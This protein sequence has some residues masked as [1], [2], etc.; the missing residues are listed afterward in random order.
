MGVC[1]QCGEE[2][3][4]GSKFC[5]H[6]GYK[7]I[8]F[9][10]NCGKQLDFD[11][12]FC[13]N[14]GTETGFATQTK[15]E[16]RT[17]ASQVAPPPIEE[18]EKY[19]KPEQTPKTQ[20]ISPQSEIPQTLPVQ[21]PVVAQP[22]PQTPQP[23][24]PPK[25]SPKKPSNATLIAVVAIAVAAMLIFA[26]MWWLVTQQE[27]TKN[28]TE[29][30]Q[31]IDTFNNAFS[32]HVGSVANTQQSN[33]DL[34]NILSDSLE[35]DITNPSNINSDSA[36]AF[37][38]KMSEETATYS[39][40]FLTG[41]QFLDN[42][43]NMQDLS[44]S[45][46]HSLILTAAFIA[47]VCLV[48]AAFCKAV[49]NAVNKNV[50]VAEL[51]IQDSTDEQ[52]QEI[53]K[54][55]EIPE[56][57]T[58]EE[59]LSEYQRVQDEESLSNTNDMTKRILEI[60]VQEPDI[61]SLEHVDDI[62]QAQ[63]EAAVELGKAG[64]KTYVALGTSV[65]GGQG[66]TQI[67]QAAGLSETVATVVDLGVSAAGYQ[68]LDILGEQC[69]VV[70]ASNEKKEMTIDKPEVQ[71]EEAEAIDVL[72]KVSENQLDDVTLSQFTNSVDSLA[73]NVAVEC[74]L[75]LE[76]EDM[77]EYYIIKVPDK[78][79]LQSAENL[80][81]TG[82]IPIPDFGPSGIMIGTDEKVPDVIEDV[83][84][85]E[86]PNVGLDWENLDDADPYN[87]E[88][89]SLSVVTSPNDPAPNQNVQV[90]ARVTPVAEGVDIY[91]HISG[92]DGYTDSATS[93]TNSE[94]RATFSIP[95]GAEDVVDTVTVRIEETGLEKVFSYVF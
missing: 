69:D 5:S 35:T 43:I 93:S 34:L 58:R 94:G 16:R 37:I 28:L 51:S 55:L 68:P 23:Q 83:D 64:V 61:S 59:A 86:N 14:C 12:K 74:E 79:H 84:T 7:T 46:H 8:K 49:K 21:Q 32:N 44:E 91:F 40:S 81:N 95:G 70:V 80:E 72:Q 77:G 56:D 4:K 90:T 48:G 17:T 78:I 19:S 10:K 60:E 67:A 85:N 33:I 88:V 31:A 57:S 11:S 36:L 3:K 45:S 62:K 30:Q 71:I 24:V 25:S 18:Q 87:P 38:E 1:P 13:S 50:D 42:W 63:S 65:T 92:T 89:Y 54:V 76:T 82:V 15:K 75:D 39:N 66:V 53:N 26:G 41:Y 73:S 20:Q 2:I 29:Y 6:C 9:C 47:G 52:L 27:P 22:A